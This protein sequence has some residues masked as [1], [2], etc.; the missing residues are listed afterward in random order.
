MKKKAK[1][2]C[3]RLKDIVNRHRLWI[4]SELRVVA[5]KDLTV[6]LN[7]TSLYFG[8]HCNVI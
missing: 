7:Y 2:M 3:A 6:L 8:K 1:V 4:D 5:D